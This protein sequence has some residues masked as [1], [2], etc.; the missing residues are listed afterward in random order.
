MSG[1]STSTS[2]GTNQNGMLSMSATSATAV[3]P[4]DTPTPVQK[5]PPR[6]ASRCGK[7]RAATSRTIDGVISIAATSSVTTT[8]TGTAT[9]TTISGT[10]TL[11]QPPAPI[12]RSQANSGSSKADSS[13]DARTPAIA[14]SQ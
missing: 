11:D 3:Q 2:G 5:L 12:E 8:K 4:S 6:R 7:R 10:S 1:G 9:A 14:G 13:S